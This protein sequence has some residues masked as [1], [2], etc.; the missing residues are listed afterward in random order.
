M[1]GKVGDVSN[2]GTANTHARH[3]LG[4]PAGSSEIY[5]APALTASFERHYLAVAE[6]VKSLAAALID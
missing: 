1:L 3:G 5:A 6:G 4:T 2:Q